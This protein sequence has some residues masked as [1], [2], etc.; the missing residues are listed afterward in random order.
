MLIN[1][2]D[3][4]SRKKKIEFAVARQKI[5]NGVPRFVEVETFVDRK[6]QIAT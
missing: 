6:G 1:I 2:F 3:L 4:R 5:V